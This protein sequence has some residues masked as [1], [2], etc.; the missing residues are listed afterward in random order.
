MS[1]IPEGKK[2]LYVI[3]PAEQ[4]EL[5][6]NYAHDNGVSVTSLVDALIRRL[7]GLAHEERFLDLVEE[8]RTYDANNRKR[9]KEPV[10]ATVEA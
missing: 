2:T 10:S 4:R 7:P 8:C 6:E 3:I 9:G 5:I 1:T